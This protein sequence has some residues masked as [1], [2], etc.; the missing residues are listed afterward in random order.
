M[1]VGGRESGPNVAR[2]GGDEFTV[3]LT[4]MDH[5]ASAGLVAERVLAAI[6][7]PYVF[8]DVTARVTSSI[9]I[10]VYDGQG[11][12]CEDLIKQA[13]TAMYLAKQN[14]KN[15]FCFYGDVN[16]QR[17]LAELSLVQSRQP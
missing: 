8:G 15:T 11:L 1:P 6:G 14:G 13:D 7:A 16:P 9:G 10:A 12:N 3:L 17:T 5:P 4:N 2:L